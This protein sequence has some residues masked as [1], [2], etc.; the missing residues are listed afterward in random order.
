MKMALLSAFMAKFC[1][2]TIFVDR[3]D[4]IDALENVLYK[5]PNFVEKY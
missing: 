5:K 2:I 3:P 1:T 4:I